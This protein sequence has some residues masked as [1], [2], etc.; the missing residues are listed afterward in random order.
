MISLNRA[1]LL[2]QTAPTAHEWLD[3]YSASSFSFSF[4]PFFVGLVSKALKVSALMVCVGTSL[5]PALELLR[6]NSQFQLESLEGWRVQSFFIPLHSLGRVGDAASSALFSL[7][8]AG[9]FEIQI[10]KP[11]TNL[12][13]IKPKNNLLFPTGIFSL[14]LPRLIHCK[15]YFD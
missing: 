11:D 15:S 9:A 14:V 7:D 8:R 6:P 4:F 1:G 3:S 13:P 12:T 10:P 5:C 2:V